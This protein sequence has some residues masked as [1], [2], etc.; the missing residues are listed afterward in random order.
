MDIFGL[1]EARTH[2]SKLLKR[3]SNGEQIVITKHGVPIARLVPAD[4]S[5]KDDV[6][7]AIDDLKSFQKT[8]RLKGEKILD[9]IEKGR[10]Y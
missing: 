10:R 7:A 9:L 1:C 5:K 8:H 3:V 6:A 2:W 4:E